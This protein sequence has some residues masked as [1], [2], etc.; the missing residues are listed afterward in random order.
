MTD[1]AARLR[2]H[3]E[4]HPGGIGHRALRSDDLDRLPV[5]QNRAQ[6]R[7]APVDLRGHATVADVGVHGIGEIDNRRAARQTQ[8]GAAR[9]EDVD[10]VG[11]E[12]LGAAAFLQCH[13]MREPL[14]RPLLLHALHVA[15]GLV[16]P[17]RRDAGLGNSVHVLG[18][19]L[20]LER[21]AVRAEQRGMQRLIAVR[22]RDG[23]VILEAVRHGLEY[24]MYPPDRS[25]AGVHVLH[26][27]AQ[28]IDIDYFIQEGALAPHLFIDAVE[29]LL[30]PLDAR[31]A[32]VLQ[33]RRLQLSLDLLQKFLLIAARALQR[34]FEHAVALRVERAKP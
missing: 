34:A 2:R 20:H 11:K 24:A 8:D 7:Q 9:R 15:A 18:S 13:E 14:A 5:A 21:H 10:L 12:V 6:R 22:A 1:R 4:I 32:L 27:D 23:D 3:H 17:M 19:D 25:I 16:L 31:G 28:A 29:M 33:E 30:A 26:D